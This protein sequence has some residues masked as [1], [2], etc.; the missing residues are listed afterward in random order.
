VEH[1][2]YFVCVVM[3]QLL[4]GTDNLARVAQGSRARSGR[5]GSVG[6]KL[7]T[8]LF[9]HLP[10]LDLPVS[11]SAVCTIASGEHEIR[12]CCHSC[13][14]IS[15]HSYCGAVMGFCVTDLC[16][17]CCGSQASIITQLRSNILIEIDDLVCVCM[18]GYVRAC[19]HLHAYHFIVY[20]FI[21]EQNTFQVN[22]ICLQIALLCIMFGTVET[23]GTQW[24]SWLRHCATSWR[25]VGF[26]PDGI[27][28]SF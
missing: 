19:T 20:C 6:F 5:K 7:S 13:F 15:Y 10:S 8:T 2:R 3:Q 25:V 23:W 4:L 1:V 11:Y 9:K 27:S 26:I 17:V 12:I 16:F 24:R 21:T 14:C 28:G 18:S 22:V